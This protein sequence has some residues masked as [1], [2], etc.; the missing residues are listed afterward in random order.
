M[1]KVFYKYFNPDAIK[2]AYF[3]VQCWTDKTVKDSVGLKAFGA[4]LEDNSKR[5]S[6]MIISGQFSPQRGF[7]F[8]V[9]K[10]SRTLRTKTLLNVEDALVYQAIANKIAELHQ[11]RL[12]ELDDFVFGSVIAPDVIK[13]IN[14]LREEEPN[15]YFF[16]YWKGLFKKFKESVL[17]SIEIDQVKYKFETDITGFFDSIPHYNLLM[18]LSKKFDVED[19][20]LDILADAFN[21]WSGTKHSMTPGVGIPQG[22]VPSFFFANLLLHELDDQIIGQGYKYYRYMDDIHIYGYEESELIEA[23]LIIDKY[24]KSNGLSINSKKTNIQEIEEGEEEETI[25]KEIKKLSIMA[26]Y[27]DILDELIIDDLLNENPQADYTPEEKPKSDLID[28][29]VARLSEQDQDSAIDDYWK[30]IKT[31][32]EEGEIEAFWEEQFNAAQEGVPELFDK[33]V[34][35]DRLQLKEG[36]EDIDF[37]NLSVQY[38]T[39]YKALKELGK[40]VELDTELIKYWLFAY[41]KFF[42]RANNL[43]ITLGAYGANQEIK[44]ALMKMY[45][46]QFKPYEWVRYFIIMALSFNQEFNDQELRQVFFTWLKQEDS[47]L[48]K[49]SLYRLLFK[50]SKSKQFSSSLKKELQ[51]EASVQLKTMIADFNRTNHQQGIDMIE[52]INTIGL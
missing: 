12:A 46:Y 28:K 48:V 37:I 40:A 10:A 18:L 24:T 52:F 19:E 8:Y 50:H 36:V 47:D 11:P 39:S 26:L 31:L 21:I 7:K 1:S 14:L 49:I 51:K 38:T 35:A 45:E 9:P 42:W 15:Y 16:K 44:T 3:R 27:D 25:R 13:G 2:L 4:N 32:K 20:I 41:E 6:E 17:H 22:T 29:E 43:G 33:H 23:L 34:D 30:N 5:L